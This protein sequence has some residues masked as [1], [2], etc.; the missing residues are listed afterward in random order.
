M[1]TAAL[2]G[3]PILPASQVDGAPLVERDGESQPQRSQPLR[4]RTS[5]PPPDFLPRCLQL[6]GQD[7]LEEARA[8]LTPAVANHPGWARAHFYLALTFHGEHRYE[9]ARENFEKVVKLDPHN[10][11]VRAYYGWC[12]YYLG[13]LKGSRAM[14]ESYL[15]VKPDYPDA[16]FA[17]GLIDFDED[18]VDSAR[19]RFLRAIALANTED[20]ARGEAKALVRLADVHIRSGEWQQA[21]EALG[22]SVALVPDNYEPYFKLSRVLQRLGDVE[23][24]AAAREKHEVLRRQAQAST[25]R[26]RIPSR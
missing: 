9:Q 21:K 17:L 25:P 15:E 4:P 10:H 8:L 12:L 23:G 5:M 2:P 20:D 24:A 18:R 1:V 6:I 22:R 19:E 26:K 14:F 3:A 16:I 11:A 7:R 13:E